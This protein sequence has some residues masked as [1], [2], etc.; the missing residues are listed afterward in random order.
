L[1]PGLVNAQTHGQGN[2]AKGMGDRW[3]LELLLTAAPWITGNRTADDKYLSTQVGAVE[4]V[5]NGC[6]LNMYEAMRL[7]SFAS[8]GGRRRNP[9]LRPPAPC[10][11]PGRRGRG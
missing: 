9:A 11:L 8:K 6:T 7:A 2:L 4:M 5:M 1:H 10:P 3:P